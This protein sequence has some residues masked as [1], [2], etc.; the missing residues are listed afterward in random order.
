MTRMFKDATLSTANYDALLTGWSAQ[1]TPQ[2]NVTFDGGNS[3]YTSGSLAETGRTYLIETL[4]WTITDGGP[5]V[6]ET[7]AN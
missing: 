2:E 1:I 6:V 7:E 3:T 5:A 4:G